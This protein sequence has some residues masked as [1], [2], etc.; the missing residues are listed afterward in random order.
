[1]LL[2]TL[3]LLLLAAVPTLAP[4]A[5]P[6]LHPLAIDTD[7]E[8]M[9]P[10]DAPVR[11]THRATKQAF[12]ISDAVILGIVNTTHPDGPFNV[13]TLARVHA[14][15]EHAR[16]LDAVVQP[17][18]LSLSTVDD[19]ENTGAGSLRFSWMMAS[20]PETE[21]QARNI[22]ARALRIPL[23]N[24]T[25]VS[26]D[27]KAIAIYLPLT[28]KN[29][30]HAVATAMAEK[31]A[32]FSGGDDAFH[33][34]GLPVAEDTFGHEMFVQMA[35][36]AP[37]AMLVIFCLMWVFFRRLVVIIAPM[38][39][40]M[41][42]ALST[43]GLLVVTGNT[44]HI[45][46]SMIPIFI[47][48][49][50]VLDAVH[51]VSDFFDRYP[52]TRDRK[53]TMTL[54]MQ[55]L[56]TPM[57]FTSLTTATGFASLALTPIPP[58]QV[59]G[60]FVAFGVLA[61]WF[62]TIT[63]LPAYI[64]LVPESALEGFGRQDTGD[65]QDAES[66][67]GRLFCRL[68][69]N[70]AR[71]ILLSA[72]VLAGVAVYGIRL[73][74]IN[75]NPTRWFES[76]HPIR[77]ADVTLNRHFGGTYD[78]YLTVSQPAERATAEALAKQLGA[79]AAQTRQGVRAGLEGFA[80]SLDATDATDELAWLDALDANIRSRRQSASVAEL[81]G[82]LAVSGFLEQQFAEAEERTVGDAPP[83]FDGPAAVEG[84]RAALAGWVE[85]VDKGF[86]VLDDRIARTAAEVPSNR[87]A[88]L[89]ALAEQR[90]DPAHAP[91]ATFIATAA[92]SGEVFKDPEALRWLEAFEDAVGTMH[93]VGKTNS[94]A[95][96]VK[97]VH[98]DLLSG[99][100]ADFRLPTQRA[101]VAQTLEQYTSSH[102]KDDLW[103]FVTPD[104][105]STVLWL[106]LKSGD[107]KDM[108]Q[109]VTE[110][111]AWVADNPPPTGL[112]PPVW[113]GLTYINLIWQQQMVR[114][115]AKAFLSSFVVVLIMMIF[116]FRSALW[117]FISMLPL[118]LTVGLI[119]GI[120]GIIGKDY[121]MPV[122][123]LSSLSLGLAI[124]YAIHF[125][126][127][128]RH[129]TR[130][131]GSWE[132]ARAAV[133]AEPARAIARNI[134]IVGVGFL[135]LLLAPLVPYQTVGVLIA[136]IL[137]LAGAASLLLLPALITVLE[138]WLFEAAE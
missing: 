101:M 98:R 80:A 32:T 127:R 95:G 36:T 138:P 24:D 117:G 108:E 121:D 42:A 99:E 111:D 79:D 21:E 76:S 103:H 20:P 124:D 58:V 5:A 1:M 37:M 87:E 33:I 120:L 56:M 18:L 133:F 85:R 53:V 102:R 136:S 44:I 89:A 97:T 131:L 28:E 39:V 3:L 123:V 41:V 77:I 59:F 19:I 27:A 34:A 55:D 75:D 125:L 62:W 88:F 54:V 74:E 47:M 130:Q 57:L 96:I 132:A 30:A 72:A 68:T 66:R 38:V 104:Y 118:T 2:S 92:Q 135:P 82:L 134:V 12:G 11:V 114:G 100:H 23:L 49:I 17:D 64:A 109:L 22:R 14:L 70:H 110:V 45:M 8:N 137:L 115:M 71:L 16:T 67:L 61:A 113:S 4:T 91:A 10:H 26:G 93:G 69:T 90:T 119:Y 122:A 25:L 86:E 83:A 13:A 106:A 15:T 31:I 52:Q 29:E 9:L 6:F 48:P 50:A 60:V 84:L 116:L 65:G 40:A 94:L 129:L 35:I 112:N 105:R 107:N 128:S 63:F 81:P 7:P 73:I 43:M 46:S 51:I 78:A 126:A